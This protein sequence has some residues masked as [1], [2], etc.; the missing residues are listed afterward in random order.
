MTIQ[1]VPLLDLKRLDPELEAEL[2]DAFGRVLKSGHFILGPEVEA[3]EKECAAYCGTEHAVGVS[4]GTD[5]LL[6]ALMALGVGPGDEV[7]CPTYT[8]FATAGCVHRT[9]AR[10]VFVDSSPR[11]YNVQP[12]DVAAKIGPRTKAILPVH[13]F[14][15]CAEMDPIL[16]VARAHGI[17]VVEDAAQAIGAEYKGRRAGSMG[18]LGC[19]SF[20]PSKNLGGLG[21][22]GLVTT[23]D[24]ALADKLRVL[25][26]HGGKPKYH[27]HVVGG[28]FRLDALQA[29]LLRPKLRR[30]D[31]WTAK[32]QANAALYTKLFLE[33]GIAAPFG[34]GASCGAGCPSC[35]PSDAPIGL[36]VACQSRHIHNQYVIRVRGEGRRN[37]LQTFL[38][39]RKV[40]TEVYYPVPMHQQKCFA[41]L[42][43]HAGEFPNAEAAAKESLALPIFPELTEAEI[44]F[45]VEQVA[46]FCK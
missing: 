24:A 44:A 42:E 38:K 16:E 19:F 10:P 1:S 14:G 39:D 15:Q 30:L 6:V 26:A 8:F 21:D 27:H 4:S 46:A 20:F 23:N 33:T 25:R 41:Y 45:V 9:G 31:G 5:A 12:E 3:L 35:P 17:P 32:R 7:I 22:G 2:H 37:G 29:A 36:P 18:A 34:G 11:C 43:H 13:L 28:N 40:G